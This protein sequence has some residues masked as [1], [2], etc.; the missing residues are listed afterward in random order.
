MP[1]NLRDV[2]RDFGRGE[3]TLESLRAAARAEHRDRQLANEILTLIGEWE[4]SP[5]KD[6]V[7]SRDDL[8]ARAKKL[9]PPAPPDPPASTSRRPPGESIYDA[10]L[11]GQRRRG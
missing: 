9:V 8:R 5:Q 4:N 3:A 2:T 6:S 1:P 11:R 10:G 7:R